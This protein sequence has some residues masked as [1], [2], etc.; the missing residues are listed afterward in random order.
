MRVVTRGL[1]VYIYCMTLMLL[2]WL[3]LV[4]FTYVLY[5]FI[6]Y[7]VFQITLTAITIA[8]KSV[9]DLVACRRLLKTAKDSFA[10][11]VTVTATLVEQSLETDDIFSRERLRQCARLAS[12]W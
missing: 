7:P 6:L 2:V 10:S 9:T 5:T 1:F 12:L 11:D 3:G 8:D 4:L